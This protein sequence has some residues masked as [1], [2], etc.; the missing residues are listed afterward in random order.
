MHLSDFCVI[1]V[2]TLLT[3]W[4]SPLHFCDLFTYML[5]TLRKCW[6]VLYFVYLSMQKGKI[7]P[8]HI[9][10][11]P[12]HPRL[13]PKLEELLPQACGLVFVVDAMDFMPQLR[14]AAEYDSSL[15]HLLLYLS[16]YNKQ[17]FSLL[18]KLL[19]NLIGICTTLE[20]SVDV[21]VWFCVV[22]SEGITQV[23][24]LAPFKTSGHHWYASLS[25]HLK[26]NLL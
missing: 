7:K 1:L 6:Q 19:L 15:I 16:N 12:G 13:K 18:L 21:L 17:Q 20:L 8:V 14:G 10:D 4:S 2:A 5:D 11:V 25:G 9:V 23:T 3:I 26:L 22:A 24:D